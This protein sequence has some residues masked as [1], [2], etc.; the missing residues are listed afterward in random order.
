MVK[1]ANSTNVSVQQPHHSIVLLYHHDAIAIFD[2]TV[3][4]VTLLFFEL[5]THFS[6]FATQLSV[7]V[8]DLW[9][10]SISKI[11][12][13]ITTLFNYLFCTF[14]M[15]LLAYPEL[16]YF[17]YA[18]QYLKNRWILFIRCSS[19]TFSLFLFGFDSLNYIAYIFDCI[20]HHICLH[21]LHSLFVNDFTVSHYCSHLCT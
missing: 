20:I 9:C 8:F 12:I 10:A 7:L 15:A 13:F 18:L 1:A 19:Q 11:H 3:G 6:I 2:Y 4:P 21:F 16:H 14:I 5:L 17:H